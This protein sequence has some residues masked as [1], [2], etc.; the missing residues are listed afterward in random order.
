MLLPLAACATPSGP[1]QSSGDISEKK[2]VRSDVRV[3]SG[4]RFLDCVYSKAQGPAGTYPLRRVLGSLE[5]MTASSTIVTY[6]ATP[7]PLRSS[8]QG[9]VEPGGGG[10]F[11]QY[12]MSSCP[13]DMSRT[14]LLAEDVAPL[15]RP[16]GTGDIG[17]GGSLSVEALDAAT[18]ELQR[19]VAH[20]E[21]SLSAEL[22]LV[23]QRH[24]PGLRS[25]IRLAKVAEAQRADIL[26]GARGY[27]AVRV[28]QLSKGALRVLD[29]L[30][31]LAR[32]YYPADP[33]PRIQAALDSFAA[34]G[35]EIARTL[36]SVEAIVATFTER[37][38]QQERQAKA[39]ER[40]R[41]YAA[42]CLSLSASASASAPDSEPTEYEMCMALAY[43]L[44]ANADGYEQTLSALGSF[45]GQWMADLTRQYGSTLDAQ[46][47]G[48]RKT[49][50]CRR[51]TGEGGRPGF[52]CPQEG[53][54]RWQD[55]RLLQGLQSAG[56]PGLSSE[57]FYWREELG[58]RH[59]LTSEQSDAVRTM[60]HAQRQHDE[61]R[62]KEIDACRQRNIGTSRYWACG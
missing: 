60:E 6:W 52:V 39:E 19:K 8:P 2:L 34:I 27:P 16:P 23:L 1:S 21:A 43:S 46:I 44:Q 29:R 26:S 9:R 31:S 17:E 37:A 54:V 11:L 32:Q 59:G 22:A 3:V 28:A 24:G 5:Q 7:A 55:N 58:W 20:L 4:V 61:R 40:L 49:G 57:A 53:D 48:F 33:P 18:N 42:A 38:I 10:T 13:G 62:K 50:S 12:G 15:E 14:A 25:H 45:L 56:V 35:A 41:R 47:V 36:P 30:Q 51:G